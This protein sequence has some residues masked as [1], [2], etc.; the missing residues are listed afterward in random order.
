MASETSAVETSPETI[1][2]SFQKKGTG[3]TFN[4]LMISGGLNARNLEVLL[5]DLDPQDH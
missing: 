3:K 5:I 1:A 4:S 2:V